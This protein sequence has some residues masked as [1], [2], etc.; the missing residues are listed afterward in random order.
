[1]PPGPHRHHARQPP[2]AHGGRY[3]VLAELARG[4]LG[5]V[6]AATDDVLGR[7]VAIKQA[8]ASTPEALARFERE[9]RLTARLQHA[10]VVPVYDVGAWPDGEP[11]FVMKKVEGRSLA[12]LIAAA[13]SLSKR[14]ALVPRVLAVADTVAYAHSVGVIH[15]DLKPSN[16]VIS[17]FGETIVIDWGLAKLVAEQDD[18]TTGDLT[19]AGAGNPALTQMGSVIGT[20]QFMAPEQ[21]E[22]DPVDARADVYA[23]GAMLYNVV[24][25]APPF[26]EGR[27]A[28]V[29][30]RVRQSRPRALQLQTPDVPEDLAA[31]VGK[32]MA[33]APADRYATAADLAE[34]LQRF[35]DG[36]LVRAHRYSLAA[37]VRRWL[38]RHRAVVSACV[39]LL[40]TLVAVGVASVR[41]IVSERNAAVVARQQALDREN[42]LV[43]MQA[44]RSLAED[45]TRTLSWLKRYRRSRRGE[46]W[47]A[48]AIAEDAVATGVARH[49]LGFPVLSRSVSVAAHAP[50]MAVGGEDGR[51]RLV[52]LATGAGRLLAAGQGAV[53][54]TAFSPDEQRLA[55]L[56]ADGHLQLWSIT[57][58]PL[59][60][61]RLA[62]RGAGMLRFAPDGRRLAVA[63]GDEVN[64]VPAGDGDVRA[65]VSF[66]S[67]V[68]TIGFCG[69]DDS[70]VVL[71][72][73]GLVSVVDA[74]TGRLRRL[75]GRHGDARLTCLPGGS[76][77]VTGGTDGDVR[78]WDMHRGLL[79]RL[80]RH[81]DWVTSLA[82]SPDGSSVA[83]ASGDDT[84]RIFRL[85][86][87]A[88]GSLAGAHRR[89]AAATT[90]MRGHA[91][92]V[93]AVAFSPDGRLLASV[94]Y[95]SARLW[96][97]A[98]G[99][100]VRTFPVSDGRPKWLAITDGGRSLV[101]SGLRQARVWSLDVPRSVL[102][103]GHRDSVIALAWSPDGQ[104]LGSGG[105]DRTV[106][107]HDLRAGVTWSSP[108]RDGWVVALRFLGATKVL[109]TSVSLN[110]AVLDLTGPRIRQLV[111]PSSSDA[112]SAGLLAVS[113]RGDRLAFFDAETLVLQDIATGRR[114]HLAPRIPIASDVEFSASGD[115]VA[116]ASRQGNISI[117]DVATGTHRLSIRVPEILEDVAI[118]PDG[119]WL[120]WLARSGRVDLA[121]AAD[122]EIVHTSAADGAFGTFFF[123]P[124]S[125]TLVYG[126]NERT[127]A[128]LDVSRRTVQLLY[129]HRLPIAQVARSPVGALLASGDAGGFIRLW[130]VGD[131][132]SSTFLAPEGATTQLRFSPDGRR[133]A[134][135]GAQGRVRVWEVSTLPAP[136]SVDAGPAWL[137]A[138]TSS[139]VDDNGVLLAPRP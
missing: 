121:R 21:A 128:L 38:R 42:K 75:E 10:G 5:R 78:L 72:H 26:I 40:S 119:Q 46:P 116:S 9:A 28:T 60:A 95:D 45:P 27:P 117:W 74:G 59:R 34:D 23:I 86:E 20:P 139:T 4:G 106:R 126:A 64:L 105:R 130:R 73:A 33:R 50:W 13:G 89:P 8:L 35:L 88:R 11:F 67:R 69:D 127:I 81:E 122:G 25:G 57:G 87:G 18:P 93:R 125:R 49:A 123:M 61:L 7:H 96:D 32:A 137:E 36:Q 115:R 138:H 17:E 82:V 90:V 53:V 109:A 22:G 65:R 68:N 79:R 118:S 71:E 6:L 102:I 136:G 29:L 84:I 83:S 41:R 70:L 98:T 14:L 103:E 52:D 97:A 77:F 85:G 110:T 76:G 66:S 120:A 12:E 113:P 108:P 48:D 94:S 44:E 100:L 101:T 132:T 134:S 107:V 47:Q 51:I 1:M 58:Q 24:T 37:L 30:T 104:R 16:V 92:T 91:D 62:A 15:R 19:D 114:Q 55:A 80:G 56:H 112:A 124:D 43:L 135:G 111:T 2:S 63:S 99:A 133:L 3:T 31:I 39:L 54:D 131:G 129:G